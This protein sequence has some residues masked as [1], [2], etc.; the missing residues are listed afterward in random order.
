VAHL[1]IEYSDNLK[2]EGNIPE[3]VRAAAAVLARQE[4]NH[5]PV[6][7]IGGIRVRAIELHDYCIAD[8][9]DD[10]AFLHASL[11]IG[12]GRSENARQKVA[13]E[14]FDLIKSHCAEIYSRRYLALS[15]EINEFNEAGTWKHNNIHAKFKVV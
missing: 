9:K 10:Y 2:A 14:L 12:A 6:F 1:V 13:N 15:L 11:K 8:G 5:K 7:P 4:E 3:L